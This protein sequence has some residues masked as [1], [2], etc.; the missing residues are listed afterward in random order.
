MKELTVLFLPRLLGS[1]MQTTLWKCQKGEITG[2]SK[3]HSLP[4]NSL[5][6]VTSSL[7]LSQPF[8]NFFLMVKKYINFLGFYS[9]AARLDLNV[10]K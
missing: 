2:R 7:D 3:Q 8:P 1:F 9:K 5:I 4:L 6:M 10:L